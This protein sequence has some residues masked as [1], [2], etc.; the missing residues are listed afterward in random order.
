M[1]PFS[2]LKT[3]RLKVLILADKPGW[4][5]NR[6]VDRLISGIPCNFTKD[7]FSKISSE[8]LLNI[9][10]DFDLIYYSNFDV[11]WH[12]NI[13]DKIKTPLLLGIRSHRYANFVH[14]LKEI[15]TKCGFYLQVLNKELLK[16]FPN[17]RYIPNGIFEQF[18][19]KKE[20]VVGFAG[21][22]S[23]YKGFNLIEQACRELE[24]KFKPATG[25]IPPQ[26]MPQYYNSINLLVS[27]SIEEGHCNP[28]YE[29]MAMN[30][31][32]ITTDVS[33][34]KDFNITRVERS[35]EGIKNGI[36]KFYTA[37]QVKTFS[38][39]NVCRQFFNYFYDIVIAELQKNDGTSSEEKVAKLELDRAQLLKIYFCDTD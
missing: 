26:S 6:V 33:A 23:E 37:P 9:S 17:A 38:W 29:C 31:P 28:I 15:V 22:P 27:A 30:V 35:V 24:V 2:K 12:Y 18:K 3:D 10:A 19:P 34:V 25:N 39:K 32:V 16:E 13:I 1:K 7:Y 14:N 11:S 20:F 5:I 21:V 36:L 4:V 8:K